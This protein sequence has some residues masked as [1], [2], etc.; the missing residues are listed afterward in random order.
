MVGIYREIR[1]ED[2]DGVDTEITVDIQ[3][4]APINESQERQDWIQALQLV[5]DPVRGPMILA[6]DVLLR[7]T[8]GLFNIRNEKEITELRNFGVQALQ[9]MMAA[10]QQQQGGGGAG[11]QAAPGPG[12]TPTQEEIA[13]QIQNQLPGVM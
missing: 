9:M 3:S 11:A 4:L 12:P 8:M 7:K 1:A 2:L 10:Q 5:A 13:G 6:S